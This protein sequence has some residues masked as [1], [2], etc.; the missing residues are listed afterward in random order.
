MKMEQCEKERLIEYSRLA[1]DVE[2]TFFEGF[3]QQVSFYLERI[4][5]AFVCPAL[6]GYE[7]IDGHQM[8]VH[9][10][11]SSDIEHPFDFVGD[12][13]IEINMNLF[14]Y[15]SAEKITALLVSAYISLFEDSV[16]NPVYIEALFDKVG[17]C[18][19]K[20][21]FSLD[22]MA[23]VKEEIDRGLWKHEDL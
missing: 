22:E 6:D 5:D 15:Y 12:A 9:F 19:E 20:L 21:G 13:V 4:V 11:V 7:P 10:K 16:S 18:I 3:E 2:H 1:C 8:P 14:I 23:D 17:G